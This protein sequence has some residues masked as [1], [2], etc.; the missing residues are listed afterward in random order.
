MSRVVI[1]DAR[2]CVAAAAIAAA[3]MLG[4]CAAP[5]TST[6]MVPASFDVQKRQTGS[7]GVNVTG[8][9]ETEAI[10]LPQVSNAAFQEAVVASLK[11]AGSFST[12]AEGPGG[13][14]RLSIQIFRMQ[15]PVAGLKMTSN[16]EAGWTLMRAAT[17]AVVWQEA[18]ESEYTA[19]VNDAFS[20]AER[21][22]I[23]AEGAAREN[24]RKA[25][26]RLSRVA[27]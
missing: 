12:V 1:R 17:N 23:S 15:G 10:G 27:L 22:R 7:V 16:M 8:G 25:L 18:I 9:R 19:T 11:S 2:S 26:A 24:I 21:A 13:D 4:G 14:F 6:G 20:G 5:A 3:L